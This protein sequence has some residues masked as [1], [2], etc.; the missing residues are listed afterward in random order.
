MP[1]VLHRHGYPSNNLAPT[2]GENF[3][4]TGSNS[5]HLSSQKKDN[6]A[7]E[8]AL[9]LGVVQNVFAF[10]DYRSDYNTPT[11]IFGS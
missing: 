3:F 6:F 8:A 10:S 11:A 4:G 5:S 2:K 1:F 9:N 7:S